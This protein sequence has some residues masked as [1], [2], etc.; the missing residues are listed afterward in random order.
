MPETKTDPYN[1]GYD[2]YMNGKK[3]ADNP[4]PADSNPYYLWQHGYDAAKD[5][6]ED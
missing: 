2:A 5:E 1:E 4:Y 3:R 6:T